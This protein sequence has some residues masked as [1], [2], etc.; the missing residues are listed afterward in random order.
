M[1]TLASHI[2]PGAKEFIANAAAMELLVSDMQQRLAE[3]DR[4][5][6]DRS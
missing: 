2:D 5:L 1:A 3:I 4:W 6:G